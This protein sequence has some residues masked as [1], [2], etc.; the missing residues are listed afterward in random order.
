MA[1][2][3]PPMRCA[4]AA[5]SCLAWFEVGLRKIGGKSKPRK[6]RIYMW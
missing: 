6:I 3:V 5:V 4:E 1:G 2:E